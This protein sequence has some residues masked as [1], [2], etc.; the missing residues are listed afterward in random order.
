MTPDT[1]PSLFWAYTALWVILSVYI[2]SLG[3]RIAQLEKRISKD[4]DGR[5]E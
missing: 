3:W 4:R 5:H 2:V 1:Y